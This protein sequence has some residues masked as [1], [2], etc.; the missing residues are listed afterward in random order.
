MDQPVPEFALLFEANPLPMLVFDRATLAILEANEAAVRQYGWTREELLALNLA[1]IRRPEDRPRMYRNASQ[2]TGAVRDRGVCPHVTR[3]GD[4]LQVLVTVSDIEFAGRPA[5]LALCRDVTVELRTQAAQ[6]FLAEASAALASSL[7][8]DATLREIAVLAV[9]ALA[10]FC[11]VYLADATGRVRQVAGAHRDPDRAALLQET[12]RTFAPELDDPVSAVARVIRTGRAELTPSTPAGAVLSEAPGEEFRR[13]VADLAPT[14]DIVAPLAGSRGAIGALVFAQAE[15]GRR[16]GAPDLELAT[17]LGR[18][19]GMAVENARLFRAAHEELENRRRAEAEMREADERYRA[20][21]DRSLDAVFVYGLDGTFIDANAAGLK[22]LGYSREEIDR[23]TAEDL[24]EAESLVRA[25]KV[26]SHAGSLDQER[27]FSEYVLRRQDGSAVTVEAKAVPLL[28]SGVAYGVLAIVRDVSDRRRAEQALSRLAA[29]VESSQDAIFGTDPLGIITSWNAGAERILG[30]SAQEAI[31]QS[32]LMIAPPEE[33]A[34]GE[35]MFSRACAGERVARLVTPVRKD[36]SRGQ[37]SLTL[38]PTTD[39]AGRLTGVGFIAHDESE[40]VELEQ[41]LSQAQKME[42]IGR[43]AGGVA[44]DFNNILTGVKGHSAFLLEA[45]APGDP[46]RDEVAEIDRAADRAAAL[47]RQLLAFGRRQVLQPRDLDLN[48]VV[49][50]MESMLRRVL[51]EDVML[52]TRLDRG[53]GLVRADPGQLQQ[54]LLNLAVNA[55]DAMP[56]GGDLTITTDMRDLAAGAAAVSPGRYVALSVRDEGAGIAPDV[57]PHIFEPFFTT[58]AAGMGTGLG[59]ATVYGIV[60][61]SGGDVDVQ[62]DPG[63]GSS[64]TVLLPVAGPAIGVAPST[65]APGIPAAASAERCSGTILLVE[66]EYSVRTI[67]TRT[68]RAAGYDV[69]AA[70]D[71]EEALRLAGEHQGPI[72]LLVSDVVLPGIGGRVVAERLTEL[73]PE[74]PVLFI[75]G[76]AKDAVLRLGAADPGINFLEKPFAPRELRQKIREV[77]AAAAR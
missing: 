34:V 30:F 69:L 23:L 37:M 26:L 7:D 31:G 68:L 62:T 42:A 20:L 67:A 35:E 27:G 28:R 76:Y 24:F 13:I 73:R 22:L 51:G 46:R 39:S 21:F 41:K 44:H 47:T 2:P 19:A 15:S 77:L 74:T 71:G 29:I 32:F 57:M 59:L 33:T 72:H 11:T 38:S 64:F 52:R 1:D 25:K 12:A 40:R 5:R 65:P 45:L 16:F 58:K 10:D 66:D 75:S 4:V 61:Q 6:R 70:A 36:G 9:P 3:A 18:R 43:L 17:E 49:Q 54:V 63:R 14:S 56:N 8:L 55:R 53:I 48:A 60:S 50:D